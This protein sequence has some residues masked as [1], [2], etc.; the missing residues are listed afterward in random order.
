MS[1]YE[2]SQTRQA[3]PAPW[4]SLQAYGL[5][6]FCLLL[7]VSLGY[8][9]RGSSAANID[10]S[11]A[12]SAAVSQGASGSELPPEQQKAMVDTAAAPLLKTLA[13]DP[14]NFDVL[15]QVGNVYYDGKQFPEAIGYY[16]RALKIHPD[17]ADVRTDLGTAYWYTGDADRAIVEFRKSLKSNPN[18]PGTLFNLGIVLWQG[19]ADPKAA[20]ASWESLLERN[21]NYAQKQQVQEFIAKAKQQLTG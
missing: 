14:G 7:G 8:I 9:F 15:V 17:N 10:A 16:D 11:S 2:T 4:T 20:I 12:A 21:P 13:S 6:A 3:A 1:P 18:H 19:K 5:A